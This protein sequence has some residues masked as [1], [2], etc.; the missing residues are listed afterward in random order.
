MPH[1]KAKPELIWYNYKNYPTT[2]RENK[3]IIGKKYN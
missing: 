1:K 2:Q 3:K